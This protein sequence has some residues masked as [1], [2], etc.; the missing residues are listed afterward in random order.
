[1]DTESLSSQRP[2][3][4]QVS[5]CTE[6]RALALDSNPY[7]PH[8][9]HSSTTQVYIQNYR[10]TGRTFSSQ[11]QGGQKTP[12]RRPQEHKQ[13]NR[14]EQN[15]FSNIR[16]QFSHHGKSWKRQESYK[17]KFISKFSLTEDYRKQE[18]YKKNFHEEKTG[19]H[20]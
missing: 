10:L 5:T 18:R 4:L 7:S 14:T 20:K 2:S 13:Q 1:M 6:S 8:T 11:R 17:A 16:I 3:C 15:R 19:E 12:E 9:S